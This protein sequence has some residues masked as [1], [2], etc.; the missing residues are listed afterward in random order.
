MGRHVDLLAL[1]AGT[2]PAAFRP[3]HEGVFFSAASYLH[4]AVAAV[5]SGS[6]G[7]IIE[8]LMPFELAACESTLLSE[9]ARPESKRLDVAKT[10]CLALRSSECNLIDWKKVDKAILERWSFHALNWIKER[11]WSGKCFEESTYAR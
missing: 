1:T 4:R 11:A 2:V 8:G 6:Q 5:A 9:I 3:S 10:Y 7:E